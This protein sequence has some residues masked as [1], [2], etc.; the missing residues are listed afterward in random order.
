MRRIATATVVLLAA[1]CAGCG[2]SGSWTS[3]TSGS[4]RVIVPMEERIDTEAEARIRS[5]LGARTRGVDHVVVHRNGD[6]EVVYVPGA[7]PEPERIRR[8]LQDLGMSPGR[9]RVYRA[10]QPDDDD[11]DED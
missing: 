1:A 4:A 10:S 3:S 8:L 6:V 9:A 2:T 7:A 5:V 11:S